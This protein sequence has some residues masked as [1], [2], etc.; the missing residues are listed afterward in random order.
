MI[1]F[2]WNSYSITFCNIVTLLL[3]FLV[4]VLAAK[5]DSTHGCYFVP[6][7]SGLFCPY[8]Q[9]DARGYWTLMQYLS[10]LFLPKHSI[11]R[12][13]ICQW[14]L[15]NSAETLVWCQRSRCS[16]L[17]INS[18][19]LLLIIISRS[20]KCQLSCLRQF[21]KYCLILHHGHSLQDENV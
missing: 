11:S 12:I 14:K 18:S 17:L 8:W 2:I 15:W 21:F 16:S 5:V 7:F 13:S 20:L 19:I 9:M 6:A 10:S 1:P 4:E 3:L